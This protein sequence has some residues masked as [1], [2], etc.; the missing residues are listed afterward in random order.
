[1]PTEGLW[2]CAI[3]QDFYAAVITTAPRWSTNNGPYMSKDPILYALL[4]QVAEKKK[5]TK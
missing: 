2:T 1:M 3:L 5:N 4:A